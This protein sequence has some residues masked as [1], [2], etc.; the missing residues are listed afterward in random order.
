MHLSSISGHHD[1]V[2][3]TRMELSVEVSAQAQ[4]QGLPKLVYF[5]KLKTDLRY[6]QLHCCYTEAAK[7]ANSPAL[8]ETHK[9]LWNLESS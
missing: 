2:S 8:P 7:G 4:S 3:Y 6:P 1:S 9:R 5:N